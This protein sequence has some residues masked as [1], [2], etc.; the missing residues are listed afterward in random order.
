MA[1]RTIDQEIAALEARRDD[2]ESKI[3]EHESYK[4]LIAQGNHGAETHFTDIKVLYSERDKVKK[5][6][7]TLY[8]HKGL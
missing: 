8:R 2:L 4:A 1:R 7:E 6:L 3:S 5:E